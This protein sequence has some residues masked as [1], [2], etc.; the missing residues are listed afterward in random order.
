MKSN[1]KTCCEHCEHEEESEIKK[2]I[3]AFILFVIGIIIKFPNEWINNSIYI[4]SYLIVGAEI[5]KKALRNILKGEVFD[6][7]F[8]M[9]IATIGA[10]AIGEFPEAVAVMLFYQVGEAFQ[11]YAVD[12]SKKSIAS[13]MQIRPDYANLLKNEEVEKVSPNEIKIGDTILIKPGEKKEIQIET[14]EKAVA[15][16]DLE[17]SVKAQ[18]RECAIQNLEARGAFEGHAEVR[19]GD[20]YYPHMS[21]NDREELI[22]KEMKELE[23]IADMKPEQRG[24]EDLKKQGAIPFGTKLEDL[25]SQQLSDLRYAYRDETYSFIHDY[26]K[27]QEQKQVTPKAN[28]IYRSYVKYMASLEDKTN[29]LSFSKYAE[30]IYNVENINEAMVEPSLIEEERGMTR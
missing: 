30:Q 22:Q 27:L 19:D 8:L 29:A 6:E 4:L 15:Y 17:V 24:F 20:V 7:N 12:K 14:D 16:S 18:L 13:L 28:N 9:T 25:P 21:Y 1:V 2:I 26:K 5:V 11:D 10:F 3:I 23:R